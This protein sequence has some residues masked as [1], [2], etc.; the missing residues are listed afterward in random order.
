MNKTLNKKGTKFFQT[1]NKNMIIINNN[2][3][4]IK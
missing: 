4:K 3:H 1:E 2:K